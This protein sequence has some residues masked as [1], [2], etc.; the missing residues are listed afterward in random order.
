MP[1]CLHLEP[2]MKPPKP[3]YQLSVFT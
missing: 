2:I 1:G 3:K